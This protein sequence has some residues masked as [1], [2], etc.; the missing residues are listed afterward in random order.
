VRLRAALFLP[1]ALACSG[2]SDAPVAAP[3]SPAQR[4]LH[5]LSSHDQ[6]EGEPASALP[7]GHPQVDGPSA[8]SSVA[9]TVVIAAELAGRL[10]P[11]DTLFIIGRSS[12]TRQILAVKREQGVRFP[13]SF[14]ISGANA[15]VEGTPFEGPLDITARISKTGDAMP[16]RGDIEGT[17]RGV[18]VGSRN[19][20]VTLDAVRQ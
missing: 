9:G 12:A 8:G 3:P 2:G 7:P 11:T 14:E 10:A 16:A 13:Y 18:A 1:F 4:S 5:A 6:R 15:M 20:T 19:L 17:E